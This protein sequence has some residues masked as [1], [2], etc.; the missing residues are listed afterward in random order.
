MGPNEIAFLLSVATFA[1]PTQA[2]L[3]QPTATATAI[4]QS[5]TSQL[6]DPPRVKIVRTGAIRTVRTG[7]GQ[8]LRGIAVPSYRYHREEGESAYLSSSTYWTGLKAVG[9]NAIRLVAF[10]GWQRSHGDPGTKKA[11]PYTDLSDSKQVA[12]MLA[13]FD[14]I[15]NQASKYG[16]VVMINFHDVGNYHDPDYT[17]P[18]DK[19]GMFPPS[20]NWQYVIKFWTLVAP[21]YANRNHV[22]YELLNEPVQ[23]KSDDYTFSHLRQFKSLF[24]MVRRLAPKTHIVVFSFATH[25]SDGPR[26]TRRVV[27]EMIS[28]GV[29]FSN[30]SIGIH[31]YNANYP[32]QNK[33]AP[34][35]DLM[36]VV[37]V[38]NTEQNF[39]QGW[40]KNSG[41]PD[42]S[43]MDGDR[44]G[45]QSM[46]RMQCSWFHWN[47]DNP[48]EFNAYF[49][50]IV[51]ADA[52]KKNYYWV[53]VKK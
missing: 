28:A 6:I 1:A 21:R 40:L 26:T 43:G 38:I 29:D 3:S 23:W 5:V 12:A 14:L 46:E 15:V 41:D 10:D 33:S 7:T 44:L 4:V 17:K 35:L 50:G 37:A 34:L 19:F 36:Q 31:P 51:V 18:A 11:Y 2:E 30:A 16:M 20:A 39:P 47:V 25:F 49:R 52:I 48:V 27:T 42:A 53:P 45:V 8:L 9:I 24:D 22:F 13:E 32:G